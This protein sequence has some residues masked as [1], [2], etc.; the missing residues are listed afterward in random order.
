M[1][2]V[3]FMQGMYVIFSTCASNT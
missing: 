3:N 2:T 1:Y